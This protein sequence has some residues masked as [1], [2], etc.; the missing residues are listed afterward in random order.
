[1]PGSSWLSW[2]KKKP[3][4]SSIAG[5]RDPIQPPSIGIPPYPPENGPSSSAG[6]I[7]TSTYPSTS[8]GDTPSA[9]QPPPAGTA[10]LDGGIQTASAAAGFPTGPYG[11]GG[12]SPAASQ[13]QQGFYRSSAPDSGP[14][15]AT[16]DARNSY[17]SAM[18]STAGT[19]VTGP[20][21]PA[22]AASD[23]AGSYNTDW[24]PPAGNYAPI[25]TPATNRSSAD[26]A[27]PETGATPVTPL[28]GNSAYPVPAA[29]P[30]SATPYPVGPSTYGDLPA[31]GGDASVYGPSGRSS[32]TGSVYGTSGTSGAGNAATGASGGYRPGSTGRNSS[33]LGPTTSGA[34]AP[35][36][37]T[38][39]SR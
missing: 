4:R 25:T 20:G 24:Q 7:A 31:Y 12:V 33:L 28:G 8:R 19:A 1:M 23:A 16:A 11:T 5:T 34:P 21:Y 22:P 38:Y 35:S 27:Y 36:T 2:N 39:Y 37:G 18:S 14:I 9:Y 6:S 10:G 15:A 30:Y 17:P 29:T 26:Y 3:S 32:A 13:T